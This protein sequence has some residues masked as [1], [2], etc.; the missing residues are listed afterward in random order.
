MLSAWVCWCDQHLYIFCSTFLLN[1]MYQSKTCLQT[2]Y[3][4]RFAI[5]S[6]LSIT[7]YNHILHSPLLVCIESRDYNPFTSINT[8]NYK[9]NQT[10][11]GNW[12]HSHVQH[13]QYFPIN[14]HLINLYVKSNALN[15][16]KLLCFSATSL[17]THNCSLFCIQT[18]QM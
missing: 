1:N 11:S 9:S 3:G 5:A 7:N 10:Q 13:N 6:R 8:T 17:Y 14:Y 12:C 4:I 18:F 2:L 16:L 15:L